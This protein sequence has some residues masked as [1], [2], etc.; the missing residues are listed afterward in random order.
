MEFFQANGGWIAVV[1]V[2]TGATWK[3]SRA[4]SALLVEQ[5][6]TGGELNTLASHVKAQNGRIGKVEDE[7]KRVVHTDV[8]EQFQARMEDRK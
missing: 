1:F 7:M 3:L 6:K 2:I 5:V 8:F 4:L